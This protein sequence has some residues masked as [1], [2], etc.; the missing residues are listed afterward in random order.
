MSVP[1]DCLLRLCGRTARKEKSEGLA[2]LF[3]FPATL[4]C[5]RPAQSGARPRVLNSENLISKGEYR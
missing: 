5:P 4:F 2:P 1:H 3:D